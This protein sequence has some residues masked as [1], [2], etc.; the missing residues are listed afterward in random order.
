[1]SCRELKIEIIWE[2]RYNE[3]E[4]IA[5]QSV[6]WRTIEQEDFSERNGPD[7]LSTPEI[8]GNAINILLN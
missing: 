3:N 1:M 7:I 8:I 2:I 4:K 5:V 6:G